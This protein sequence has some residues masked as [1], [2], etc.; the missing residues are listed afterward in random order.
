[1]ATADMDQKIIS[2]N[3]RIYCYRSLVN[4]EVV[5]AR[6]VRTVLPPGFPTALATGQTWDPSD[7]TNEGRYIFFLS[8]Y[9]KFELDNALSSFKGRA[10]QEHG[11]AQAADI[12]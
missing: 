9:D 3:P 12:V 5:L 8:E 4:T 10:I 7:F 11:D 1:M 2:I 6:K